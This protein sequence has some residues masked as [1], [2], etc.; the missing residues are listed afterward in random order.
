MARITIG[1]YSYYTDN[2]GTINVGLTKVLH[3]WRNTISLHKCELLSCQLLCPA[4][5][6]SSLFSL[7]DYPLTWI[8]LGSGASS[9]V[10]KPPEM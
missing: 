6:F 3:L 7:L 10:L 8:H 1:E 9:I 2:K 4:H 5:K